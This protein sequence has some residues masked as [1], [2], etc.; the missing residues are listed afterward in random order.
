MPPK[1]KTPEQRAQT[2]NSI[3]DAARNLFVARGVEA[4]T[5]REIAKQIGCSA[6]ALYTHFADKETLLQ[7]LCSI[8]FLAL[9]T[10]MKAIMALDDPISRLNQL[11]LGYAEFALTHPSHY[12]LMFMTPHIPCEPD[13]RQ[14]AQGNPEQ[15]AYAQLTLMVKLAFNAG[16]FREELTESDLIAQTL[17]AGMH[18]VCALE[19]AKRDDAWIEWQPVKTRVALMQ[20]ALMRGL[21]KE[22]SKENSKE[23]N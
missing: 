18:G 4:V 17:W 12:R 10:G 11:A 2:R 9:A 23:K 5:M 21:L 6:T 20:E 13:E 19:I 14:I 3:L 8:D 15:D 16:C 22:N 1:T 7:E